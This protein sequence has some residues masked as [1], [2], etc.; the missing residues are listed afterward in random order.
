MNVRRVLVALLALLSLSACHG[1]AADKPII[2]VA[3]V[4]LKR[5]MG[6]W[7]VIAAIPTSIERNDYNPVETYRLQPNGSICTVFRFRRGSFAARL[8]TVHSTATVVPHTGNAQWKVHLFWL[9]RLQYLVGWLSPHYSRVIVARDARDYVWLMARTPHI[10]ASQYRA[11]VAR[12]A[13]MGYDI[14]KLR[15]SPQRWPEPE[16]PRPSSA[17]LCR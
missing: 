8:H 12:V 4:N 5:Y 1:A 11:M 2:P 14:K 15:K 7:Y 17:A 13:A 9:L 10:T 16:G 3:H 6:R